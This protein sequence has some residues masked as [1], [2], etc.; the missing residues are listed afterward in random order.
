MTRSYY[1]RY[2]LVGD[3]VLN[4]AVTALMRELY[5]HLHVGPFTVFIILHFSVAHSRLDLENEGSCCEQSDF[6]IYVTC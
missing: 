3:S 2:E 4:F 6:G 1:C 5:P